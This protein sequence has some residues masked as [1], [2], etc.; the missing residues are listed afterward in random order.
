MKRYQFRLD[1]VR[2]VRRVQ[3]DLAAAALARAQREEVAAERQVLDRRGS[4]DA[5]PPFVGVHPATDVYAGRIVWAAE[6]DALDAAIA[7]RADAG[8]AA[9]AGREAW[10][11]AS[12]RVKALDLLDERRREEHRA[13]MDRTEAA[14]I[15]DLVASRHRIEGRG[16]GVPS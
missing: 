16:E 7:M 12:R 9:A 1:Q 4:I 6:L 5:R 14:R 3:E 8:R 15:D 2:R 10:S 11:A 13:E